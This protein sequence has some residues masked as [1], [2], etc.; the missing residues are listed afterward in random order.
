MSKCDASVLYKPQSGEVNYIGCQFPIEIHLNNLVLPNNKN[1]NPFEWATKCIN[2]F[3][4]EKPY[5]LIPGARFDIHGTRHGKG[6]GWYDRF[7][8]QIPST[9]VRIGITD[10]ARMSA[11]KLSRKKLD[12][13]V[14]WVIVRDDFSWT[15]YNTHARM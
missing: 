12:E 6:G 1:S 8:S 7:L 9:W 10:K 2:K 11:T 15:V 3:K 4:N 5:V 13:P 14:D